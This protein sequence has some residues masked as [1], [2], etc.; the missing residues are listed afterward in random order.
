MFQASLP[1]VY[2]ADC[3]HTAP[4][5]LNRHPTK[6]LDSRTPYLD[7]HGAQPSYT[8]LRVFGC[9]CYPNL[10]STAPHK[11]S[12]RS[13]LCVFLG[14][15]SDHKGHRCLDLHYNHILISR[16]I[17]FDEAVFPFADMSTSP[18]A[19]TTLDFLTST[20]DSSLPYGSRAMYAG[21]RSLGIMD[22]APGRPDNSGGAPASSLPLDGDLVA[23]SP[24]PATI[25]HDG[26]P[27]TGSPDSV[28]PVDASSQVVASSADRPSGRTTATVP[29]AIPPV[30]NAHG[31]RTRARKA[32]DTPSTA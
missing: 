21:S 6:T 7:L 9:A 8:H 18:Q 4:Y 24:V 19:P 10:S 12:P 2:W 30:T 20:D 5:L 3:L 13:S 14:Y 32:H 23:P 31:M 22:A 28:A 25:A 29:Q 11:L 16:H 17:V 15:S 1:P 27:T 26:A